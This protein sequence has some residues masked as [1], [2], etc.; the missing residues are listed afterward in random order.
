MNPE[1]PIVSQNAAGVVTRALPPRDPTAH[2]HD[3][4]VISSGTLADAR[5]PSSIPR[6]TFET[7]SQSLGSHPHT[8]NYS[9]GQISSI[10][11]TLPGPT[12]IT[13]TINYTGDRV[14]S[15]VLSGA[16]PSG[17]SLTKTLT[18]TG[19]NLTGVSYS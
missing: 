14:T 8:I 3:A 5:I 7:V 12:T 16:T 1:Y 18:Y 15:I 2:T 9:S 11:Y 13:K 17:I 6:V 10:V 4:S 19:D